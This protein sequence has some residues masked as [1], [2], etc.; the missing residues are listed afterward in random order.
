[1]GTTATSLHILSEVVAVGPRL[2][3]DIAKAYRKLGY[4]R[5][6][7]DGG[8]TK[9]VVLA[10]DASGDWLSVFDSDNDRIDTGEL[11]QLAVAITKKLGTVAL[12]T[13]VYDSDSFE[14]VMFHMGKQVD[15]AVSDPE[16]HA[17]GLKM[18]K[19]KRRAR[20]WYSMFI[21]RDLPRAVRAGRQGKLLEGWEERA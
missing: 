19:G 21:G 18:L 20:A 15:A 14:F 11:K 7:K 12:L 3:E 9:R 1:M 17:G 2:P 4:A 16:V 6:K 10:P 5:P 8:A 13:S